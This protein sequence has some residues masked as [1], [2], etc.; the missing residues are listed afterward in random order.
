VRGKAGE[1]LTRLLLLRTPRDANAEQ[2]AIHLLTKVT[3]ASA[4]FFFVTPNS[5]Y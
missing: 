2:D 5:D 1:A 3:S 4:S